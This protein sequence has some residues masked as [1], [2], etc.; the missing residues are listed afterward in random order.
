MTS[1]S[2][3][4]I[5]I[6]AGVSVGTVDRVIHNRGNVSAKF[7]EKVLDVLNEFEYKPNLM[8]R[9][10][11]NKKNY[12]IA[13]LIPS[14]QVDPFWK[15]PLQGIQKADNHI[16]NFG[17]KIDLYYYQDG[18]EKDLLKVGM[19]IFEHDYHAL[20]IAPI[21]KDEAS[22]I[23]TE[24]ENRQIPYVQI[25]TFINR[26]SDLFLSFVGQD[27][28]C[29][30]KLAA[31]LFD[32]G[33]QDGDTLLILHLERE[34][35]NSEHLIQKEQGFRDYFKNNNKKNIHISQLSFSDL[36]SEEKRKAFVNYALKQHSKL[37]G[38]FVTTSKLH[39]IINDFI[40]N[41]KNNLNFIGFDLL[42]ENLNHLTN[43]NA[44]FLINQNPTQQ[45][46]LGIMTLFNHI[47]HNATI[48][49]TQHLPIDVVM[50]E[51]AA[52]YINR[53]NQSVEVNTISVN[54]KT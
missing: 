45:G 17:F 12:R 42:D 52:F 15:L 33:T 29:S 4:D 37:S 13:A 48:Q 6:K 50:K 18:L 1:I 10:L 38:V 7:R 39:Y 30:G 32:F 41:S 22:I 25:N 8:A 49:K 2:L 14:H 3:K 43:D 46:Y 28:Y 51:N 16:K 27:S 5:A 23:F 47:I 44:L 53:Q 31:K 54:Q 19:Q 36:E 40:N 9:G 21:I 11:A 24:C 34:V 20:L 35:Y 26:K